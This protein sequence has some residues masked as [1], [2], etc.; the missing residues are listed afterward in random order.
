MILAEKLDEE[1]SMTSEIL[2]VFHVMSV[3]KRSSR[4]RWAS[5]VEVVLGEG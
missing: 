5:V 2:F 1:G 4:R 3:R